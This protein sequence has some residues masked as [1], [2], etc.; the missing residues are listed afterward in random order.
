MTLSLYLV[1]AATFFVSLV[2]TWFVQGFA[3]AKGIIDHPNARSSHTLPTPRGGGIA[4]FVASALTIALFVL[5]GVVDSQLG[6]AL[7]GGG[8]AVAWIG[9]LDDRGALS[10][11]TRL[12]VHVGA[13]TWA[14]WMLGGLPPLQV[15]GQ[16]VELGLIG[17]VLG[18]VAIVWVLNLFNFMDGI[19]GIAASEA[20]FICLAGGGIALLSGLSASIS[21]SAFALAAA[22]AGFLVWN[23]PPAR[24]FMG[25]VGSGYLGFVI[26]I[27]A[28]AAGR[29]NASAAFIWLVLGAIFFVDATVT[30]VRRFTRGESVHQ[31]HRSHGYQYLARRW[32]S[33]KAVT[34]ALWVV[35]AMVVLPIAWAGTLFPSL[36]SALALFTLTA[37]CAVA[38]MLG[39]GRKDVGMIS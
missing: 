35:N 1:V 38:F 37:G 10:V 3:V 28:I 17:D 31:A 24:I 4:I 39:S 34:R 36:S 15:G 11:R 22:S 8:T 26:A 5:F 32:G 25:D 2:L 23:W 29:E 12:V 27:L 16:I 20:V 18:T 6:Y 13:A 14:M 7:L 9:F 33:H 30:I 21:F 19:D